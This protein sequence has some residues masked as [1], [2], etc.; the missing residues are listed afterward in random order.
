MA[1]K[2]QLLKKIKYPRGHCWEKVAHWKDKTIA[3]LVVVG[4]TQR[5]LLL[6]GRRND[7]CHG[8]CT[9][10]PAQ[11]RSLT[12]SSLF[13]LHNKGE[14]FDCQLCRP[15]KRKEQKP[16][17]PPITAT[18][19]AAQYSALP[20][21]QKE[22]VDNIIARRRLALLQ[23]AIEDDSAFLQVLKDAME[24][25]AMPEDDA[26]PVEREPFRRYDAYA[27]PRDL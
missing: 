14:L 6:G 3:G 7:S 27:S 20:Q 2:T 22:K 23:Q 24:L 16:P 8:Y 15:K 13:A 18:R 25:A 26:P 4:F 19:I 17:S 5:S 11:A 12:I 10:N 9:C 1:K 21:A